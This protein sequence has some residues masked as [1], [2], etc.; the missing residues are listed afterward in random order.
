MRLFFSLFFFFF[1]L[2]TFLKQT[3]E[4]HFPEHLIIAI[5]KIIIIIIIIIN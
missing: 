3:T 5:N 2:F 1:S 4:P